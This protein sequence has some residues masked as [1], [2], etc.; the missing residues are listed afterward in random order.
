MSVDVEKLRALLAAT[1]GPNVG[2]MLA[3]KREAM[4]GSAKQWAL[5]FANE[6]RKHCTHTAAEHADARWHLACVYLDLIDDHQRLF[7]A[8]PELLAIAEVACRWAD[9]HRSMN[10]IAAYQR[11]IDALLAAVDAA[12]KAGT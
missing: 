12:R 7:N 4:Q 3:A 10:S 5:S 11:N 8:L 2:G 6:C 9:E 1:P